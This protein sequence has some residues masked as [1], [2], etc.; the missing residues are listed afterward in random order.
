MLS[1]SCESIYNNIIIIIMEKKKLVLMGDWASQP[2]RAVWVL[3]KMN[4]IEFEFKEI[5][6]LKME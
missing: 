3:L 1:Y 4:K 5:S 2:T 6:V